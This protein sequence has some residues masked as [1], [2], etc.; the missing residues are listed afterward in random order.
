MNEFSV[1][2]KRLSSYEKISALLLGFFGIAALFLGVVQMRGRILTGGINPRT[3]QQNI[4][5]N[6][7]TVPSDVTAA[8]LAEIDTD[9]DGLSDQD[10]ITLYK[11]SPYLA[12]SDSD[13][14]SDAQEVADGENPNCPRGE[15]CLGLGQAA[16]AYAV[17]GQGTQAGT[18]EVFNAQEVRQQ[19]LAAG[20]P[21]EQLDQLTDAQLE[22]L[23]FETA[24]ETNQVPQ[25]GTV[26]LNQAISSGQVTSEMLDEVRTLLV[27]SGL[28]AEEVA[29]LTEDQLLEI[30]QEVLNQSG[31]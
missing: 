23:Y 27:Q 15:T 7:G 2:F 8:D 10:E 12:D 1:A 4:T 25:A 5:V 9:Q 21:Q 26:D 6:Q 24:Q 29:S 20:V 17:G 13:G 14:Y 31:Q 22:E 16:D 19:L 3:A 30:M 11:S 18:A 28:T